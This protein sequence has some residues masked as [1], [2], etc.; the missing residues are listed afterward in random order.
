[1]KK[2]TRRTMLHRCALA[3]G[4]VMG[5]TT[6][7]ST[8]A[9]PES[10]VRFTL[11]LRCGSIGVRADQRAAIDLAA[12][13]GFQS[14]TPE[15]S[16][17][18]KLSDEQ[19]SALVAEMSE[20]NLKWGAAGLPVEF[21]R[22]VAAFR[23]SLQRLPRLARG[24]QQV[25]ATRVGT[26]LSPGHNELTYVGNFRQHASR[27]R[28]CA[29]ILADHGQRLGLEYVGPKT[30]WTSR[31]FCFIHTMAETK[32]L[33]A[34]IGRNNVGFVLDSWHWYTAHEAP[35]DLRSLT[36]H[37]VV[38]CDLND[39]PAGIPIDQQIDNRRELPAATGVIDLK[40]FL[41]VLVEIG[42]DGPVRAEPFNQRLNAMDNDAA[43]AATAQA[44]RA[45][46]ALVQ[47]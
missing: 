20:K 4:G 39:A 46:F 7:R 10:A 45:A 31:R 44:M 9:T 38:A 2:V 16:Y 12:R 24:L 6:P 36:N 8:T 5:L 40:S 26:W 25:G 41:G 34:E 33:I 19:A 30:S 29:K 11:D 28:Q 3:G 32:D 43:V 1:M 22:D 18:A 47:A 14:V 17:L 13:H 21:R 23:A 37:D 27:L 35:D 15:P 42:Y